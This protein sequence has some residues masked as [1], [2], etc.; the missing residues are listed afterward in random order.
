M[1]RLQTIATL[2]DIGVTLLSKGAYKHAIDVFRVASGIFRCE[3]TESFDAIKT[4]IIEAQ[5]QAVPCVS[6]PT[7]TVNALRYE[8]EDLSAY[9]SVMQYGPS[10]SVIHPICFPASAQ[11]DDMEESA[12][13]TILAY[14]HGLSYYCSSRSKKAQQYRSHSTVATAQAALSHANRHMQRAHTL[15]LTLGIMGEVKYV[16]RP[17]IHSLLVMGCEGA[18]LNTLSQT[19]MEEGC[20]VESEEARTAV[21][22]I[23]A[24]LELHASKHGIVNQV[25]AASA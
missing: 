14:N 7:L 1:S 20:R 3:N 19:L 15:S 5:A 22:Q 2:N 11:I 18:I 6:L 13:E 8:E 24:I 17:V 10:L 12:V 25:I 4:S 21:T 23:R 9:V 16:P